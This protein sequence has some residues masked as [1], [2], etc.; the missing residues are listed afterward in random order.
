MKNGSPGPKRYEVFK[1][2]EDEVEI[3]VKPKQY[4]PFYSK[5]DEEFDGK[6]IMS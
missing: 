4:K 6:Q 1:D 2:D 5:Y 3:E